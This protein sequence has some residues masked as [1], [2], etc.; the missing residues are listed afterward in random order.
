MAQIFLSHGSLISQADNVIDLIYLKY[1]NG[2]ISYDNITRV[3]TYPYPK[4]S[5]RKAVLNAIAHKNYATL[6]PI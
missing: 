6:T 3:E 1:L 4:K 2:I 5:L